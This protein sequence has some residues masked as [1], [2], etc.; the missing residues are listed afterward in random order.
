MLPLVVNGGGGVYGGYK[1]HQ[2]EQIVL[3]RNRIPG[4]GALRKEPYRP[5]WLLGPLF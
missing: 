5:S 3:S 1:S 2:E 4:P